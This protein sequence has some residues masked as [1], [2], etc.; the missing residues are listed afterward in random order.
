MHFLDQLPVVAPFDLFSEAA[1]SDANNPVRSDGHLDPAWIDGAWRKDHDRVATWARLALEV[2][3]LQYE[4]VAHLDDRPAALATARS[5]SA[6]ALLAVELGHGGL[7][8]DVAAAEQIVGSFIGPRPSDAA[9]ERRLASERDD[10]VLAHLP[11]D[12]RAGV[13]LRNP[14]NVKSLLRRAGI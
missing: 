7:P 2:H 9:D 14:A 10:L 11:T 5:E 6:A 1:D 13:D 12:L 8:I 4:Q 3:R